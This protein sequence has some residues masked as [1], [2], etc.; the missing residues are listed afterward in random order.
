MLFHTLFLLM[1]SNTHLLG[2]GVDSGGI[3]D[4]SIIFPLYHVFP[5][6]GNCFIKKEKIT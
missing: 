4:R 1:P 6:L 2:I 3:D 5:V